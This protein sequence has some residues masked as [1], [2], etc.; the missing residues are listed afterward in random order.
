M[1][2]KNVKLNLLKKSSTTPEFL[3]TYTALNPE[4]KVKAQNT[5]RIWKKN[6]GHPSL[7]F[8]NWHDLVNYN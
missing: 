5:Y 3:K 7:R 1:I 8:K 6:P 4:I 2:K